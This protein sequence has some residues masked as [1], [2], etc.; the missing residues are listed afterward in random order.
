M[1]V[2]AIASTPHIAANTGLLKLNAHVNFL[3]LTLLKD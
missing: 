3:L 2:S 1:V